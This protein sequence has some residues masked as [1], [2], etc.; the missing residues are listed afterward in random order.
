MSTKMW[1]VTVEHA[2]TCLLD[3]K[4]YLYYTSVSGPKTGVV[5]NIVGQVMGLFPDCQFVSADKLS[6]TQ[7]ACIHNKYEHLF[8][9]SILFLHISKLVL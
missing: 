7:K 1:E 6:E 9:C 3:K 4:V 2:R 8:Y 5:F